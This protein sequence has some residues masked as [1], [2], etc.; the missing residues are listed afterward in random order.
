ML[1]K[2]S[3]NLYTTSAPFPRYEGTSLWDFIKENDPFKLKKRETDEPRNYFVAT[4]DQER[5][6]EFV[7][8]DDNDRFFSPAVRGRLVAHVLE[9]G[10]FGNEPTDIGRYTIC[11]SYCEN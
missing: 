2:R 6:D 7:N 11:F 9:K 1:N 8:H 5:M 10:R 4:F 3:P